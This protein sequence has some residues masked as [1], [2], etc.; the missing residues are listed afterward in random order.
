MNGAKSLRVSH[1]SCTNERVNRVELPNDLR[2]SHAQILALH[3]YIWKLQIENEQLMHRLDVM[4]RHLYGKRREQVDPA[5]LRLAFDALENEEECAETD[6][7]EGG[8]P[9]PEEKP[10]QSEKPDS[11]RRKNKGSHGRNAFPP[12]LPRER[13]VIEPPPGSCTCG[14]CQKPW[15]V[16]GEE[17]SEYLDH[18]PAS[19]RVIEIVRP[20]YA[21]DCDC[22][23][24][25]VVVADVPPRPIEKGTAGSGLLAHVVV[26]KYADHLPLTRQSEMLAREGISIS[27]QTLCGWVRQVAELLEPIVRAMWA[28]VLASRVIHADETPVKVQDRRPRKEGEP[29]RRRCR[30]GYLWAYVGDAGD[31]VFEF[32]PTRAGEGPKQALAD[33]TSGY[34]QVDAYVGYDAVFT[35]KPGVQEVACWAH[36]RR[37]FFDALGTS[38]AL[39]LRMLALIGELYGVE[40]QAKEESTDLGEDQEAFFARRFALRQQYSPPVLDRIKDTLDG[41]AEDESFEGVLPKSPLGKATRYARNNWDALERYLE[42]GA[43]NI[44]NNP[45]EREMRGPAVGRRNW[46]FFGS[47]AGGRWAATLYSLVATCKRNGINPEAWFRDVLE[48]ISTHPQS[49]IEELTPRGWKKAR[50]AEAVARAEAQVEAEPA[51]VSA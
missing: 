26:S 29:R 12:H 18:V 11:P 49:R 10:D 44:D 47:E 28:S 31:V 21:A 19:H 15:K 32:T 4:C 38:P 16:I 40:R 14:T 1:S 20:K 6:P 45:V 13:R 9:D 36:A 22:E 37:K 17:T 23:E 3:E 7:S 50:E 8:E 34:L 2:A 5:Q 33:Y 35:P 39:A 41:W 46:T 51:G 43:L 30:T 24:R 48:R 25:G 42:S 27:R